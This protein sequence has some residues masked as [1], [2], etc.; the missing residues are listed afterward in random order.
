M[1]HVA[2]REIR[3]SEEGRLPPS[4][5]TSSTGDSAPAET[6]Q[7]EDRKKKVS[8]LCFF[9]VGYIFSV[10]SYLQPCCLHIDFQQW[11]AVCG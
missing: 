7:P 3:D 2:V 1:C 6:E 5:I 10:S 8:K 4:E 9:G 11:V